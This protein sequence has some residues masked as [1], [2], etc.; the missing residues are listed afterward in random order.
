MGKLIALDDGHGMGTAGKRTPIFPDG[1]FMH[2]NE[3]NRAVVGKLDTILKRCGFDTLMVAPTDADTSLSAR[4][5]TADDAKADL[6]ISIHANALNG[7]WG[8]AQGVGTYYYPTSNTGKRLA[9]LIQGRLVGGTTQKNRGIKS[10]NFYVLR[11]TDMPAALVEA[12]FMDNM[13]EALL[14]KSD[15][16]REEVAEEVAQAVCDYF[17]V[18]YVAQIAPEPVKA[19]NVTPVVEKAAEQTVAKPQG[20]VWVKSLQAAIGA[21]QDGI[22]GP[23][24]LGKCP[25]V[26][27]GSR[28]EVVRLLQE[29]FNSLGIGVGAADGI[30]GAKF[31][32]GVMEFQKRNGLVI[33]GVFGQ[34]SWKKMLGL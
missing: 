13:T 34:K 14:L 26:K 32:A 27:A 31:K 1:S 5:R 9:N 3:F 20:D 25:T 21:A 2:E 30:V 7:V 18:D 28:G 24:T 6:Y 8:D 4:V 15:E 12:A 10:A 22:A 23:E 29:K 17:S 33:D 11:A 19:E 16:F